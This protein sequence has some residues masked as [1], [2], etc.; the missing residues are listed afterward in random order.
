MAC[1]SRVLCLSVS[2]ST[3]S[4]LD[5]YCMSTPLHTRFERARVLE[6]LD[7]NEEALEVNYTTAYKCYYCYTTLISI[8]HTKTMTLL[9]SRSVHVHTTHC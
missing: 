9:L 5:F 3:D 4:E 8:A 7:R 1:V 6:A 2:S